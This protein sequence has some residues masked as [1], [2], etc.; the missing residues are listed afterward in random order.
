MGLPS[1]ASVTKAVCGQARVP[2]AG[3]QDLTGKNKCEKSGPGPLLGGIGTHRVPLGDCPWDRVAR[4]CSPQP[5]LPHLRCAGPWAVPGLGELSRAE[6]WGCRLDHVVQPPCFPGEDAET[7][8]AE[9]PDP[10]SVDP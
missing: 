8:R 3:H 9:T 7:P 6:S 5:Q 1:P 4:I 10:N 2:T